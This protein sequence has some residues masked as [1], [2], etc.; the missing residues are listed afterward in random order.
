M[1]KIN[2]IDEINISNEGYK[3]KI[4]EYNGNKDIII[5]FQDKYKAKVH[6]RYDHFKEGNIR[7]PYHPSVHN[8]GYIGQGKYDVGKNK[9]HTKVYTTWHS[10]I[11]RCYDPY[12]LNKYPTYINCYVCN[13]WHNFQNFA[14]WYEENYYEIENEKMHLDKD[15]LFK[16]NKIYSPETCIFVSERINTLFVKRQNDRGEYPIGCDYHKATNKIRVRC[17]I[18]E[19]KKSKN[20]TLEYFPLNKPFQA[21]TCYKN[22]KENYIKQM[23]DEYYSKELIPKKLYDA[24]YKYEIEIND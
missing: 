10:M 6:T 20:I 9:K 22:F 5:E 18:I 4:I 23:A 13:E 12:Y 16:G 3:M 15:I 21:F 8:I 24:M 7:N 11:S 17:N 2:R 14:K 19:N 1:K